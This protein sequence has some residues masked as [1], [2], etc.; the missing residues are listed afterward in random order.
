MHLVSALG[1][2]VLQPLLDQSLLPKLQEPIFTEQ[3]KLHLQKRG[4]DK[5]LK[6]RCQSCQWFAERKHYRGD[7]P[8][9]S[10][11]V[12]SGHTEE[13]TAVLRALHL[14]FFTQQW[15]ETVAH[16]AWSCTKDSR[17]NHPFLLKWKPSIS[18]LF[19]QVLMMH[20]DAMFNPHTSR[21]GIIK[22]FKRSF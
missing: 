18:T 16:R 5:S 14:L 15:E 21:G 12:L 19:F 3:E 7:T 20:R 13:T 9:S 4:T 22:H 8:K 17:C 11:S 6:C 1:G 2:E 10:Q